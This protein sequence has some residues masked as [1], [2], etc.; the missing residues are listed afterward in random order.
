MAAVAWQSWLP[1]AYPRPIRGL[2]WAYPRPTR[3]LPW[4]YPRPTL[5]HLLAGQLFLS[6]ATVLLHHDTLEQMDIRVHVTKEAS[7]S[8][9]ALP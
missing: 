8:K 3:G 6:H 9:H 7:L 4:A 1:W 5:A 2:P